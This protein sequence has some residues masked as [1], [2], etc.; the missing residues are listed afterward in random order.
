[1]F[2]RQIVHRDFGCASYVVA[3]GGI[4]DLE[5]DAIELVSGE[6]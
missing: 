3:N 2:F 5:R 1:M 6:A 4:A